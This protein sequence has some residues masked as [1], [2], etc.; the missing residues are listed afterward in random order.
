MRAGETVSSTSSNGHSAQ[1]NG[2][3]PTTNKKSVLNGHSPTQPTANG[4][5]ANGSVEATIPVRS[6]K[7]Y[8]HDRE[9]VTRILIQGLLDL[10]YTAAANTLSQ[11]SGYDLE[12]PAV[13]A[14]RNAVLEGQ[15]AEAEA[16]L[17]GSRPDDNG[18]EMQVEERGGLILAEGAD[19]GQMLFFMRQQK[20]LELLDQREL[21]LALMV[22]RHELTPLNHDIHQLHALSRY[23]LCCS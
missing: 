21:G 12:T 1:S 19:R 10:G 2:S 17:V 9:E 8:G 20:F 18:E 16:I 3:S 7:Y 15:W 4:S 13:A 5:H 22:L 23:G 14:F 11:E 6:P